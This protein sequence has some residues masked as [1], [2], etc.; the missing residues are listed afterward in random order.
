MENDFNLK[1]HEGK[2]VDVYIASLPRQLHILTTVESVLKNPETLTITITANKYSDAQFEE[3]CNRLAGLNSIYQVPIRVIRGD[4]A[5]ESNEK[6]KYIGEGY[7]KYINFTDD[8]L[9]LPEDYFKYMIAGCE[10]YN[11]YVSLHGV[12]LAQRPIK[13]YYADRMVLRGLGAVPFDSEVDIASNCGSLFK[14]SFFSEEVLSKLYENAPTVS[15]D[16]II[17]AT[18]CRKHNVT[19][20]VLKHQQGY[21]KHK[22]QYA[23][24]EYVFDKYTKQLGVTDKVQ[25]DYINRYWR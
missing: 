2:T 12:V 9:I 24:D 25:T 13:S 5:K 1:M 8:D 11:A 6:L 16:D 14:R 22:A 3:L 17:M 23:E 15:M 19:R 21:L 20:Y 18:A 7:G 4:N 10:K